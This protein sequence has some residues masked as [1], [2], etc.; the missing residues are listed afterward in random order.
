MPT[1]P[2]DENTIRPEVKTAI[3]LHY[4]GNGAPKITAKGEE[5]EAEKIIALAKEH[6]IPLCDNP[7]LID[8]LAQ[9]ELGERIPN[10]LYQAVAHVMAFAF[11]LKGNTPNANSTNTST[12]INKP[13]LDNPLQKP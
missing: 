9:I 10:T 8:L 12:N 6:D 2:P 4:D 7:A 11:A 5:T 13:N 3:A 1:S